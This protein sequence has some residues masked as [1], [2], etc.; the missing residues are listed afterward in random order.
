MKFSVIK[1]FSMVVIGT[2]V[3]MSAT[4]GDG[5]IT[6]NGKQVIVNTTTIAANIKGYN[7]PTPLKIYISNNKIEKIEALP[8]DETPKY[9]FKVKKEML[10]KWNGMTVNKAVNAKIDGVT[11]ATISSDCVSSTV[12]AGLEYYKKNKK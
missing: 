3:L 1:R 6:K 12:K 9:F 7:G 10:D 4:T 5:A 2:V 11:G 8:N